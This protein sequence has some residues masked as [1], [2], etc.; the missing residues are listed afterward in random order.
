VIP[1]FSGDDLQVF[2]LKAHEKWDGPEAVRPGSKRAYFFHVQPI[3]FR[4]HID[5]RGETSKGCESKLK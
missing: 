4:P 1:H 5:V 2:T 3:T